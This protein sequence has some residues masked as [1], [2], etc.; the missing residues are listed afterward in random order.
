MGGR[1]GAG[2]S[3]GGGVRVRGVTIGGSGDPKV[4]AAM[5]DIL[6]A[7]KKSLPI[8]QD[9]PGLTHY[10]GFAE[11]RNDLGN[12]SNAT[13][14]RAIHELSEGR[15]Y[16]ITSVQTIANQKALRE[17]DRRAVVHIGDSPHYAIS[18]AGR[19]DLDYS[20]SYIRRT[21]K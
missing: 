4:D 12:V 1:G 21:S 5:R 10:V 9:G 3:G 18:F 14:D 15:F 20:K 6:A 11:L 16:G 8:L 7:Y 13:F 19:H 2:H 17:S